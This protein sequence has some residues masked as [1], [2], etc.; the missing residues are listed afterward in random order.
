M[1][2]A[3]NYTIMKIVSGTFHQGDSEKFHELAGLQ[4]GVNFIVSAKLLQ[5]Q[6]FCSTE[7]I[8]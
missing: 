7:G 1:S 3:E 5:N 8:V 4:C 2:T 6:L